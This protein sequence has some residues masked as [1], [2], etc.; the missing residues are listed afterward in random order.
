M[1][2]L[3]HPAEEPDLLDAEVWD[4]PDRLSAD[5]CFDH[6]GADWRR[7]GDGLADLED[8]R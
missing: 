7:A 4:C 5:D 3:I 8:E 6:T 2:A 1:A